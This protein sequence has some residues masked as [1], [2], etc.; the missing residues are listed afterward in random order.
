ML[1]KLLN[2]P[3]AI[4][5]WSGWE[6]VVTSELMQ[7]E[8]RRTLDRLRV[9]GNLSALE[10]GEALAQLKAHAAGFQVVSVQPAILERASG[11]L[12]TPLGT[13]DAI[14]L[15][16]ALCWMEMNSEPLCLVTHDRQL[17]VAARACGLDVQH[18]P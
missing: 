9:L 4:T 8:A 18:R 5:R 11:P 15:A 7:V 6:V 2:Q 13:L 3:G 12:P 14:H 17:A 10:L 16:T 1:R